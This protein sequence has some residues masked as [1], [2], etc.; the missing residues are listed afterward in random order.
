M[1]QVKITKRVAHR[2]DDLFKLVL[3]VESYPGFVPHCRQVKL[4]SRTENSADT[5]IVSRMT[6]GLSALQVSYANRTNG[7]FAART[8]K[9]EAI[10]GPLRQLRAVWR[11][12]PEKDDRTRIDFSADFEFSSVILAA[13]ASR[14]FSSMFGAIVNAFERRADHVFGRRLNP[15]RS[16]ELDHRVVHSS[17]RAMR[18]RTLRRSDRQ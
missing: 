17:G 16:P 9:V 1:P 12:H 18:T 7:D 2:W 4:L 8:I 11:F 14:V 6:V 10:D 15:G 3:D 13:V 5:I